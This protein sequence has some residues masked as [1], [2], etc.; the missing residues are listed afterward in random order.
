MLLRVTGEA[1]PRA[2]VDLAA[3]V[4]RDAAAGHRA[5][6]AHLPRGLPPPLQILQDLLRLL[7]SAQVSR[8]IN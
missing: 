3:H 6:H 1:Q 2:Q 5:H 8:T 4:A 7:Y